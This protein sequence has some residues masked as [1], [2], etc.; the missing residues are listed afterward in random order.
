M[1]TRKP[2]LTCHRHQSEEIIQEEEI[3]ELKGGLWISAWRRFRNH[4]SD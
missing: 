1:W 4:L 2:H 3:E